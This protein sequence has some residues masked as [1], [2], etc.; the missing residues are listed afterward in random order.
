RQERRERLVEALAPARR[1][2]L[3]G[4]LLPPGGSAHRARDGAGAAAS[5]R[6]SHHS[7][8]ADSTTIGIE[9]ICE[10]ERRPSKKTPRARSPR[11][12]STIARSAAY[13]RSQVQKTCPSKRRRFIRSIATARVTRSAVAW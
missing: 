1:R 8:T 12:C 6:P 7:I 2:H 5:R 9:M 13:S 3:H 4:H 11:Q 10:V